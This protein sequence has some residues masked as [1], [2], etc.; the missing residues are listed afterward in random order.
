MSNN[1]PVA[2]F[3]FRRPRHL[4][5]VITGLLACAGIEETPIVVFG[6]GPRTPTERD[7]VDEARAV[8]LE[9]LNGR[10]EFHFH[11][12]N[13]GLS[14]S[15]I[16]GVTDVVGRYGRVIVLEDD[17]EPYP[18]F[19][20]F[21]NTALDRYEADPRIFQVAAY[22]FDV[23]EFAGR[24]EALVLP[25]TTSWGWATWSRAWARF[26]ASAPGWE[27]VGRDPVLR[28]RFNVDGSYEYAGMLERQLSG[29]GQS[30]AIVWYWCVFSHGGLVLF[31]P[32][33]LVRNAGMDGSGTH[34]SAWLR[35]SRDVVCRDTDV[36]I[37]LPDS[38][39]VVPATL[40]AVANAIWRQNRGWLGYALD[41]WRRVRW[42]WRRR[43]AT[44][45]R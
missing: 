2:L 9:L 15:I 41:S 8:A 18:S 32:R 3:I 44:G 27:R 34:G 25:L 21:M 6:D 19:L 35:R 12:S 14:R 39:A 7:E 13:R 40:R 5:S 37:T 29:T 16:D 36:P 23:P 11:E 33:T 30:W 17:L 24:S 20:D 28:R 38:I 1:A 10:A 45:S 42:A 22:M 31:P 43:T 26:D 4:R